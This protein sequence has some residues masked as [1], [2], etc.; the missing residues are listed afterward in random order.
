METIN[1]KFKIINK[2]GKGK[3]GIVYK[4]INIID[5]TPVA[6]KFESNK[7]PFML[8]K[9]ETTILSHLYRKVLNIPKIFYYGLFKGHLCT[10]MTYYTHNLGDFVE[11][12]NP[13]ES[14]LYT[15]F[16]KC[17]YILKEVHAN[18]VIHRD[19]KPQNFMILN[20]EIYLIDFGLALFYMNDDTHHSRHSN[21]IIGTPKYISYYVHNGEPSSRRDDLISI[22]YIFLFFLKGSLLWEVQDEIITQ[23]DELSFAHPSNVFRK[24]MKSME[25]IE[26]LY[27]TRFINEELYHYFQYCYSLEYDES[28]DYDVLYELFEDE[29]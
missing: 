12:K 10:V 18:G 1:N 13:L 17:I 28:P 3:F 24:R 14:V 8:L 15:L 4:G 23:H 7:S 20:N 25:S 29:Q 27:K 16:Q 5:N 11:K 2:I 19:I 26:N 6:I 21:T 22:G 9:R